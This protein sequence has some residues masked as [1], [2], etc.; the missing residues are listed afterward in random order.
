MEEVG[1]ELRDTPTA[2]AVLVRAH[3]YGRQRGWTR[4]QKLTLRPCA[5]RIADSNA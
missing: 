5:L 4:F 3:A 1:L 2:D